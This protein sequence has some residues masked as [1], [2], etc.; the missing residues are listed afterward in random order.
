MEARILVTTANNIP[1][2]LVLSY[3]Q[4]IGCRSGRHL[5]AR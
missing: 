5:V 3:L 4:K 2:R 1:I